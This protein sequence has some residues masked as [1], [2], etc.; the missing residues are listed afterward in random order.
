MKTK[1]VYKLFRERKD[2]TL[3]SIFINRK[4]KLTKNKW[5]KSKKHPTEGFKV[6]N[7]WHTV[8]SPV[9][10]HLS[11]RDRHW[12]K[13]KIRNFESLQKPKYQG[14]MWYLAKEMK[15]LEKI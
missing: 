13:V 9:A 15:I 1:I 5:I 11:E 14:G 6:R 2:G 4:A 10:P 8:K 7:G 12:Y 3:G